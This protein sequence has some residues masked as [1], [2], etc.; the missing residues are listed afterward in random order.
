M[1]RASSDGWIEYTFTTLVCTR[2]RVQFRVYSLLVAHLKL[3]KEKL[4]LKNKSPIQRQS[5]ELLVRQLPFQL[6]TGR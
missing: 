4:L 1:P 3:R 5:L 2:G 6:H